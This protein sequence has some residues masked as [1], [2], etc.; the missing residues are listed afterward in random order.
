MFWR[1][2]LM[3]QT[4]IRAQ[5]NGQKLWWDLSRLRAHPDLESTVL[6]CKVRLNWLLSNWSTWSS[7]YSQID[8][9]LMIW[10]NFCIS[11]RIFNDNSKNTFNIWTDNFH[12]KGMIVP[13]YW[14][15]M[16]GC[17]PKTYTLYILTIP[18]VIFSQLAAPLI[19]FKIGED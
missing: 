7:P 18:P 19:L 3:D 14:C 8:D 10:L 4:A 15:L 17:F 1:S 16:T 13:K 9:D 12:L 2:W 5:D 11:K 6:T